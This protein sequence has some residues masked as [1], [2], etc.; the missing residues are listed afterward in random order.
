[1]L[2]GVGLGLAAVALSLTS[3]LI[4]GAVASDSDDPQQVQAETKAATP[5]LDRSSIADVAAQVAP[6]VVDISTGQGEG[7][8]VILSADG[9]ILT[10]N[11]VVATARNGAVTVTFNGGKTANA[12]VVGT[13]PAGDIAVIK[14]DGVSGLTAAKF[15]DSSS[16]RVGDTVL[17]IGSPLGLQGSVTE[18]II[19]ALNRPIDASDGS[20]TGS[21]GHISDAIQ[22]DA[23]INPGNSGG[24]LVNLAGQVIGINTAIAT[25]GEGAGSIGLG[26]AIPSNK[27]KSAADQ[28]LAG[29][30]V[31]HPYIGVRITDGDGSGALITD[32][33]T[34]GP[35]DKAGLTKGDVIT[36]AG[37][38][39]VANANALSAA[40]QAT[41]PGDQLSMTVRRDGA[42]HE[43]SV[44]V[45]T[46][47][48]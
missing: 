14:A 42:S 33:V 39:T 44:T 11:H 47:P 20:S 31:A 43:I 38:R 4:G 36:K 22:T 34:G 6:S 28:L 29:K 2:R 25:S 18:G 30:K 7:S 37:S 5:V 27:V 19:S 24:A 32:V 8:G 1:V 26:F 48:S 3:G 15:G 12:K 46:S 23:A 17:A 41:N 13:D 35:A 21:S 45:G 16:V 40:I 10:N 9:A